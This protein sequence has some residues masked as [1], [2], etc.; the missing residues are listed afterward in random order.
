MVKLLPK[1][2][3]IIFVSRFKRD[4]KSIIM[5]DSRGR[6]IKDECVINTNDLPPIQEYPIQLE[7]QYVVYPDNHDSIHSETEIPND[8]QD[9]YFQLCEDFIQL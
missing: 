6:L 2:P 4:V 8:F 7:D 1:N 5:I 9:E 3:R